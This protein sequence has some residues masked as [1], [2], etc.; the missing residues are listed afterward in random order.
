MLTDQ[1]VDGLHVRPNRPQWQLGLR[2]LSASRTRLAAY[3]REDPGSPPAQSIRRHDRGGSG[4]APDRPEQPVLESLGQH[5]R[6][7]S[8]V[9][10][11]LKA[12]LVLIERHPKE[13]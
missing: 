12:F 11:S 13:I 10:T 9:S 6:G 1:G 7:I 5:I 3:G 8:T 4:F 2:R